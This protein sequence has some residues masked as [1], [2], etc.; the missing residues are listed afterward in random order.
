MAL[1][2]D[3]TFSIGSSSISYRGLGG[4]EWLSSSVDEYRVRLTSEGI[5]TFTANAIGPDG[6]IIYQ[7]TVAITV[8]NRTQLDD[9]LK[10][11]WE[12]MK[13][14]LRNGD[15]E[16]AWLEKEDILNTRPLNDVLKMLKLQ[17]QV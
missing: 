11:K 9:L 5:H 7:H 1:K 3:G 17:G 4:I 13:E 16:G 12:K 6:N 10:W 14:A 15:V 8:L 2:I